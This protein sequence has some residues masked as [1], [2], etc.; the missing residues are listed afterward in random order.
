ML[1]KIAE[2]DMDMPPCNLGLFVEEEPAPIPPIKPSATDLAEREKLEKK[3]PPLAE[4]T[5]SEKLIVKKG[6][7]DRPL[8]AVQ[9][10]RTPTQ[11]QVMGNVSAR[12]IRQAYLKSGGDAHWGHLLSYK[13][14]RLSG[15]NP[16]TRRNLVAIPPAQ[17]L[18]CDTRTENAL[19]R[20]NRDHDLDITYETTLSSHPT[21]KK[22][23]V[24]VPTSQKI[25]VSPLSDRTNRVS[26]TLHN[27][28][29][30]K[31]PKAFS[32]TG[33]F[34]AAGI[35]NKLSFPATA[36]APKL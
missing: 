18:S 28:T 20:K 25:T 30:P 27:I 4:S 11:R 32:F 26:M 5:K 29:V 23:F 10:K 14:A 33:K 31:N 21:K 22:K 15:Q 19:K 34:F 16:Q 3:L 36:A 7:L 24:H 17:N 35:E 6:L 13:A 2:V 12:L 9:K 8:S 1:K